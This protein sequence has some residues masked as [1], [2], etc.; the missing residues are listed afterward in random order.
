LRAKKNAY[1]S[2][3]I[4]CPNCK[5]EFAPEDAIAKELEKEYADKY[6]FERRNFLNQFSIQ[7][8]QLESQQRAFEEKKKRENELFAE[9]LQ[10]ERLKLQGELQ[11]QLRKSISGEYENKLKILQH[12]NEEHEEKLREARKKELEY[13]KKEQE[14]KNREV[15]LEIG[16]Q[17]RLQEERVHIADQVRKQE[18]EKNS[19]KEMEF[20]MKMKQLEKQLVDQKNLTEQMR[21]KQAQGSTQLQGEVQELALESLLRAAFPFDV[22]T[23]VNKGVRGADCIQIVRNSYG[24]E[25]GKIIYESKRAESFGADWIE[26]LKKDMRSTG[27][28]IAVLVTKTMPRDMDCFGLKEG[29]WVCTFSEVK[30]MANVLRDGVIRIFT[31]AKSHENRGDK[32]HLLYNYL[33]S[34]EFSEQWKA[35]REGFVAMKSGIQK[36]RDAMERLWKIRERQLEKVLLNSSH[37]KGSIE[38]I[39]GLDSIDVSL[40]DDPDLLDE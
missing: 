21:R 36:E 25:C 14:L 12:S 39:A 4:T 38:G 16:L 34:T 35:I 22:I 24:Q 15:D 40:P 1:M 11:E 31:S 8:Q 37:V 2:T 5:I 33:T 20:L 3:V 30:A 18:T 23:E 13:L 28:E 32:M 26:K 29:V 10:K 19:L 27:A 17:K 6:Q 9:K 7:Q